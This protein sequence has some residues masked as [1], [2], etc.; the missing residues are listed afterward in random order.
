MGHGGQDEDSAGTEGGVDGG[1]A[2]E[3]EWYRCIAGNTFLHGHVYMCRHMYCGFVAP[4]F[5]L[6]NCPSNLC[7]QIKDME[8]S[9]SSVNSL[10]DAVSAVWGGGGGAGGWSPPLLTSTYRRRGK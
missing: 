9:Q 10:V 3:A 2:G 7:H 4:N 8:T 6:F 5:V 1:G